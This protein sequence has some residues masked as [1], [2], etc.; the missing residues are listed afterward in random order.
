MKNKEL[1]KDVQ[2]NNLKTPLADEHMP[3]ETDFS[4]RHWQVLGNVGVVTKKK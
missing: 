3:P 4:D 2:R 1:S